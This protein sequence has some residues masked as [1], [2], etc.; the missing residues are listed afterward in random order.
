MDRCWEEG[1]KEGKEESVGFLIVLLVSMG[2]IIVTGSIGVRD[3]EV[4]GNHWLQQIVVQLPVVLA[5]PRVLTKIQ[6]PVYYRFFCSPRANH[7][8]NQTSKYIC[9]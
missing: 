4:E 2:N 1:K 5:M 7:T 6:S 3:W 9:V 8:S